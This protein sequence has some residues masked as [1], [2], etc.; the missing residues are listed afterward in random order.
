MSKF[1][2]ATALRPVLV[3]AG[4]TVIA[5][6]A[7]L[8]GLTEI[9]D[10]MAW[11]VQAGRWEP[12]RPDVR[13]IEQTFTPGRDG[14]AGVDLRINP[15]AGGAVRVL[16]VRL[17][18][19]ADGREVAS[20]RVTTGVPSAPA[21]VRV[22]FEPQPGSAG[23]IYRLVVAAADGGAL[24]PGVL[25][26]TGADAYPEG[27]L[28]L[29]GAP[30]AGSLYFRAYYRPT[31]G[32]LW[33]ALAGALKDGPALI[34]AAGVWLL[35]G[36]A[37][38][39]LL[40]WPDTPDLT[41]RLAAGSSFSLAFWPL[42]YYWASLGGLPAF[43][44][45]LG[46]GAGLVGAALVRRRAA[47]GFWP[48]R[49]TLEPGP[50]ILLGLILGLTLFVRLYPLGDLALTPWVD[51]PHHA[52]L[53]RKIFEANRILDRYGPE[54]NVPA[55]YHFGFH[56]QAALLARL[57]GSD[58]VQATGLTGQLLSAWAVVLGYWLVREW[59]GNPAAGLVGAGLAG[60]VLTFPGYFLSWSR[61]S[62]AAGLGLLPAVFLAGR[63]SVRSGRAAVGLG[64]LLAGLAV[65]H[66]RLLGVAGLFVAALAALTIRGAGPAVWGRILLALAAFGPG[67]PWLAT[68][69][70]RFGARAVGASLAGAISPEP[71][72]WDLVVRWPDGVVFLLAVPAVLLGLGRGRPDAL[73]LGF[74]VLAL[75]FLANA[76]PIPSPLP[77]IVDGVTVASGLWLAALVPAGIAIARIV[78]TAGA[79][80]RLD[81]GPGL[82][83]AIVLVV[84]CSQVGRQLA[85]VNPELVLVHPADLPALMWVRANT[86][87]DAGFLIN[88]FE[89]RPG[90]HAGSDAGFWIPAVAGR[91]TL[92]P[93]LLYGN[94]PA[95][96]FARRNRIA[97]ELLAGRPDWN[98]LIPELRGLGINYVFI[99][100]RGGP[101]TASELLGRPE[102]N[103]VY[104]RDGVWVFAIR[105]P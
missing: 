75:G 71:F 103:P 45:G 80:L 35:P 98:R 34:L 59:S 11:Q 52:L 72:P 4:V 55:F 100:R 43:E 26:A 17:L 79:R 44:T 27:R 6:A 20:A 60:L 87:A 67:A 86:P 54:V 74:T 7:L 28:R 93:T 97:R 21:T 9:P 99:G 25:A 50:A 18:G 1:R 83:G 15:P 62:L 48:G 47:R 12:E 41:G 92:T 76:L 49:I 96:E 69:A 2:A 53:V 24:P 30:A 104:H 95:D 16:V 77:G 3:W 46:V 37:L 36:L 82:V 91:T 105:P 65:T 78:G 89:W 39:V 102:F 23:Q 61:F 81:R 90:F 42:A 29:D 10:P 68:A 58:P 8:A 33:S 51:G 88:V 22:R 70:G 85:T 57:A 101:V 56:V 40:G 13:Q 32:R 63:D 73:A 31:P 19:E 14:L 66:Y 64:V 94:L 38:S 5:A 84:G